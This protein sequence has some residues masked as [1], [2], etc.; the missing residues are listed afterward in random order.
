M[1]K[2]WRLISIILMIFL[3]SGCGSKKITCSLNKDNEVIDSNLT[4]TLTYQKDNLKKIKLNNILTISDTYKD[5]ASSILNTYNEEYQNYKE[6]EGFSYKGVL[7]D[8]KVIINLDVDYI[9]ASRDIK[10]K[11][12][13]MDYNSSKESLIKNYLNL[14]YTCK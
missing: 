1:K 2:Y 14:G 3:L 4:V 8:N 10:E 11:I 5:N 13:I 7:K 12:G 9:K 6:Q